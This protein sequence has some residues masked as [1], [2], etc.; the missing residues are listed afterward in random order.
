VTTAVDRART[1]ART[2]REAVEAK[3][4]A[5]DAFRARVAD[6]ST[7]TASASAPAAATAG[8]LA[9]GE[10][11]TA[12]ACRT[13]RKAFAETIRPHSVADLDGSE[14]LL[15]TIGSEF[16]DAIAAA[17]APTTAA[18]FTP[19]L[20]RRLL[21]AAD[22]RRAEV[23]VFQR[24]LGREVAQ[25]E[26]TSETV[27][28]VSAWVTAADETPLTDLGF[29]ELRRRHETFDSHRERCG[30]L[31]RDRQQFLREAT[32]RGGEP[33]MRHR[34]LASYLYA[35]FDVDHPL[36]AT[37]AELDAACAECQRTVRKHLV[38]CV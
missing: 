29:E 11:S 34:D 37:V 10:S 31:A 1:R 35:D 18:S 27:D 6:V 25:L 28:D 14:P 7:E 3:R 21:A 17:L 4:D 36:L 33:R 26:T 20:K 13:V 16:S 9:R 2:E 15:A 24:A 8:A 22:A 30:S 32:S 19:E 23:D 5:F 38:R 12:D